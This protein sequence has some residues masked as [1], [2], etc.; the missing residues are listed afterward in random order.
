VEAIHHQAKRFKSIKDLDELIH[1]AGEAKVVLL[2]DASHGTF[3]FYQMRAELTKKLI[4][5]KGFS[6]IA[7]EG[8]WLSC[9]QSTVIL[10]GLAQCR[11][12]KS[13]GNLKAGLPGCGL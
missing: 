12:V 2:G 4:V 13:W 8:D 10:K 9:R 6:V 5:E 11:F 7:V 3:E 1:E